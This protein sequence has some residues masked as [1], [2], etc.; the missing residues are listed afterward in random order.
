M[1]YVD[2][3]CDDSEEDVEVDPGVGGLVSVED[4]GGGGCE[5]E[6]CHW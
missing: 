1:E 5:Y 4:A 2:G 6:K 3:F